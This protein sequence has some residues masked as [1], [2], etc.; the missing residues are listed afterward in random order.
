M[1]FENRKSFKGAEDFNLEAEEQI[2]LNKLD[3]ARRL[4]SI[5]LDLDDQNLNAINNLAVVEILEKKYEA[6]VKNLQIVLEKDN[7]NETALENL[8]YLEELF[9][10]SL[11]E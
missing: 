9:K 11:V 7:E 5:T 3:K 2:V 4:L 10:E 1:L 6:A 8:K